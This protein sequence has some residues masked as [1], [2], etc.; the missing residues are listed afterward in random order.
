[1]AA[2]HPHERERWCALL[3]AVGV[4]AEPDDLRLE[5]GRRSSAAR[6]V[7]VH[8]GARYE[9]K[10]W[11]PERF[12]RVAA[13]LERTR[14]PVLITGSGAER[15]LAV[16]V[17]SRAR[18]GPE[19]VLAG[20]TDLTQL[21]DLVADASLVISGDTGIAHLA[22]AFGTPS[23]VLFGPVDPAQ[24]GPPAWGP[25]I[26]LSRHEGR[27]GDPFADHPDP[28]LL[29]ISVEEVMDAVAHLVHTARGTRRTDGIG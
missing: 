9:S 1:V 20:C 14:A 26:A 8:P 21:C 23:V 13:A 15:P 7:I 5:R 18:L 3:T 12:A 19:R 17:A 28:A 29:A 11:P 25:H 2:A 6:P 4:P 10:R 27:R 22:S 16:E 24:W